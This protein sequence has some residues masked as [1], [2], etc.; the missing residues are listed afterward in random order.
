MKRMRFNCGLSVLTYTVHVAHNQPMKKLLNLM[1][2]FE[3]KS[4]I[5][6]KN[7]KLKAEI[8]ALKKE[9]DACA[10]SEKSLEL[11]IEDLKLDIEIL[12]EEKSELDVEIQIKDVKLLA[13]NTHI[14]E[15]SA[16][17]GNRLVMIE[18]GH[19]SHRAKDVPDD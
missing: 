1:I 16:I 3:E 14:E 7:R 6:A 11:Q 10:K 5:A 4:A 19:V 9:L 17:V 8:K 13:S 15:L 12:K 18:N 2:L